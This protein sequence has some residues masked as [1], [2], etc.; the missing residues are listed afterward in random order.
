MAL[1]YTPPPQNTIMPDFALK[2]VTGE[3]WSTQ[4][5]AQYPA[6]VI[7]FICNHCPYVQAIEGR[8]IQLAKDLKLINVPFVGICANDPGEYPEDAPSELLK[9]W[10]TMKYGFTYLI[11]EKQ[12]VARAFGAVCTPDFFVYNQENKL[13]Y[14]GRLDNSWKDEA[15]VTRKDLRLAVD[16]ILKGAKNIPEQSPS[17]GC[18]IKW[19]KN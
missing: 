3:N 17:M 5:L 2:T 13:I 1:T 10:Q 7:G 9:R 8:L 12:E 16:A 19:R 6:K 4:S 14:R 11:D 18:S 15:K